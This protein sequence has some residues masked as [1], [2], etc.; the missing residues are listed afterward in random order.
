MQRNVHNA[1]KAIRNK[2]TQVKLDYLEQ[3]KNDSLAMMR[4]LSTL[5][6]E[7]FYFCSKALL[8][9]DPFSVQYTINL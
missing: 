6:D 4:I 3:M 8:T 9:H 5:N 2:N 1:L 7:L